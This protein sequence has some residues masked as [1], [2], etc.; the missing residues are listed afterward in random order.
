MMGK[1]ILYGVDSTN[2]IHELYSVPNGMG[3]CFPIWN[4]LDDKYFPNE[5]VSFSERPCWKLTP[6]T[7]SDEEYFMLLA[8]FDGYYFTREHLSEMIELLKLTH[9]RKE[10]PVKST[11]LEIFETALKNNKYD[12]F[13]ITATTVAD[14]GHFV[15]NYYDEELDEYTS[16]LVLRDTV[17]DI[18]EEY[19]K[20]VK[21][22]KVVL[23]NCN[24]YFWGITEIDYINTL[25]GLYKMNPAQLSGRGITCE[26]DV[27][28]Y[29]RK[30]YALI[31]EEY[32]YSGFEVFP[33]DLMLQIND[34]EFR[35]DKEGDFSIN[36]W[37]EEKQQFDT[38]SLKEY[39]ESKKLADITSFSDE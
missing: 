34:L 33:P 36:V 15:K 28:D 26:E 37:D 1:T 3:A 14:Y 31:H 38:V 19:V 21:N 17:W 25:E 35:L 22:K 29:A 2:T 8:S 24:T 27:V 7:L 11:R 18:W 13:F 20:D 5:K 9:I 12:K 30:L 4:Y 39:I 10:E 16:D 6:Q 23:P 32:W